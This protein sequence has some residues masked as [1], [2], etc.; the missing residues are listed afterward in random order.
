MKKFLILLLV[1][2]VASAASA[3]LPVEDFEAKTLGDLDGQGGG[4]GFTANWSADLEIDVASETG[5][6]F[7][8]CTPSGGDYGS[9][10]LMDPL[11]AGG[12]YT[13]YIDFRASQKG[14]NGADEWA[15]NS[16]SHFQL[17]QD[18]GSDPLHMK[19]NQSGQF[20]LNDGNLMGMNDVPDWYT[21]GGHT[22]AEIADYYVNYVGQWAEWKFD[23][24]MTA[25][26][27]DWYWKDN[28]GNWD[29]V[30][31]RGAPSVDIDL[32]TL[33]HKNNATDQSL[34]FDN[35]RVVPEPA[36]MLML[37]LGG[38]ALIRRKR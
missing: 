1:L 16:P 27:I 26:T 9:S 25:G 31:S 10:R 14:G 4:T 13:I 3:A 11:A 17:R 38:L 37:G 2:G 24:D 23:L 22:P 12:Q 6:Q 21:A 20:M 8:T 7:W 28:S 5:N 35:F 30:G 34:D 29:L 33:S 32:L 15:T 36:T 19:L 18:G